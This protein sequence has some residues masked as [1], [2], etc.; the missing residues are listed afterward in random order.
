MGQTWMSGSLGAVALRGG[1]LRR[2][3]V[4]ETHAVERG[5]SASK[6]DAR[7]LSPVFDPAQ[8]AWIGAEL[9]GSVR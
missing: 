7:M 4:I 8:V 1:L 6:R 9:T 3:H 5:H 2:E